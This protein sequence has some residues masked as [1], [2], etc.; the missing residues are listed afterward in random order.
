MAWSNKPALASARTR[1][2][3]PSAAAYYPVIGHIHKLQGGEA[4]EPGV[5]DLFDNMI[6][7]IGAKL[8][9]ELAHGALALAAGKA[10]LRQNG[11]KLGLDGLSQGLSRLLSKPLQRIRVH[12]V[13]IL[14]PLL[15]C[16]F[17]AAFISSP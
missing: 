2:S 4:V 11:A 10:V 1:A 6:L 7:A 14:L 3:L 15:I 5:G 13:E 17:S 9:L 8:R 12:Q 16:S